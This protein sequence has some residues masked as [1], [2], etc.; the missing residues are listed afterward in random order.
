MSDLKR[1]SAIALMG[2]T[3]AWMAA[4][5]NNDRDLIVTPPPVAAGDTYALTSANRLVSF[6]L[7]E[8]SVR[9][10]VAI[11]G[12]QASETVLG[13]DRRPADGTLIALGDSGR[14]YQ[15]NPDSG[16]ATVK[17]A[18]SADAADATL[19]FTTLAGTRF[20]VD[21]NPVPDRLRVVSDSGQNLRI[22]VETG[23][24]ITDGAL[25][26]GGAALSG[27]SAA[28]YTNNFGE[29]CRTTL[30]YLDTT[31]DRLLTTTAP[32]DGIATVVG[33]LTVDAEAVDA[34]DIRTGADGS[35]TAIAALR[36]GGVVGMYT[37]NLSTGSASAAGA[38]TGLNA[39]EALTGLAL[40]RPAAA[41]AQ[42]A[43]DLY[44]LTESNRLVSFNRAAPAKLCTSAAVTGLQTGESLV[45]IDTRPA[46]GQLYALS[47]NSRLYTLDKA[48]GAATLASTLSV[49]LS[50]TDFGVDFNPVP[51][52]L[53]VVSDTGQNLR[54]NVDDGA[55]L[56][57]GSLN[58]GGTTRM[59]VTAAAY[60]NSLKGGN[61]AT[62]TTTTYYIDSNADVL[63]TS[64]NPNAGA[65]TAVGAL[66]MGID[67]GALNGFDID[68]RNNSALIAVAL[69]GGA[70]TSLHTL[71][72]STGVASASLGTVGGG[73]RLRGLTLAAPP[74][75]ATAFGVTGT[76]MLVSFSPAAPATV[77]P[78]GA[79]TGLGA[80]QTILGLDVRPATGD[81]V[82][83]TDGPSL[84][85]IDPG[86]A[87]AT[88]LS[89]LAAD[90]ADLTM[91]Y[92]ALS[93]TAFGVDFNPVPD[94]LRVVSNLG[95]SL[96]INVGSGAT[97][98]DGSLSYGA[99][100]ASAAAYTNSFAGTV[101]TQLFVVDAVTDRLFLQN[102][103]NDGVLKDRGPLGVDVTAVN[104]FEI[105]G[106]TT[107]FA[108]LTVG[109]TT[110]LYSVDVTSAFS[111]ARATLIG[112][113]GV[114]GT[115]KG[116]SAMPA[117]VAPAAPTLFALATVAGVDT[118]V[119]FVSSAPGVVTSIAPVTG[120]MMGDTLVGMD[121]RPNGGA[122]VAAAQTG[123]LYTLN[124]TTGVATLLSTLAADGADMTL[125]YAGLTGTAFGV[126][127]NPVPDRLRVVSEAGQN[128]RINVDTGATT[129]DGA[130]TRP[131]QAT[132]AAYTNSFAGTTSTALY[133]LDAN[134]PGLALVNPP[135][136]GV[137][138]AVNSLGLNLAAGS[139]LSFDIAGGANGFVL[140]ALV[141]D[142][143]TQSS[144]YR[145]NLATGEATL[146]GPI[147]DAGTLL[148]AMA[149]R[150]Q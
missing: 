16:V 78:I 102:P 65:L 131:P 90:P 61:A 124:T 10:A 146:V 64:T 52:R 33:P 34:F 24:T 113:I 43:G 126:D 72:L 139:A 116:L 136:D 82:A 135:N 85:R 81:L 50:G 91:P 59:G 22:N 14:L 125:Q 37:I 112:T 106:A 13:L 79:I 119:S 41:P 140:A 89:T 100:G 117:M 12:L 84:Y 39:G 3:V 7:A 94:R 103:P 95:Q 57:D 142:G 148:N 137:M 19:P 122:L 28:A 128:L 26:L 118:L 40:T 141:V 97:I 93:G 36:V 54:V 38:V 105:V 11:S 109:G 143:Q 115:V 101:S 86:T 68:G 74:A 49:P 42:A 25:T 58:V 104:G 1:I 8:R 53:R 133:V 83:F 150:L 67:I 31:A 27:V 129:T 44:G 9:T 130:L 145:V 96:R 21:F 56:N 114:A 73:E 110:G 87:Q 108:A 23:A 123:R 70:G 62:L 92:S 111:A 120:L 121:F 149:L 32:N 75:T 77:T 66:G 47:A 138:M 147:G 18:L 76:G 4:C 69:A 35:Q 51:D 55:T 20:G 98:T 144:L 15:I 88:L 60:T 29:T 17:A 6:N 48:T 71:D 46:N 127:F 99:A 134:S 30:Y 45:G 5:S 63:L 2:P 107:A 132:A 80:S